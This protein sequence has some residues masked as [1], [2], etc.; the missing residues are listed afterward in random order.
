MLIIEQAKTI[1]KNKALH[2]TAFV[3]AG[4]LVNGLSLF[5]LNIALARSL[6]QE[7]FG[8]FSLSV[9]A[10]SVVA[11][12][13]DFGLNAGLSRFAPY[14][15]ATNQ[16]DKLKQLVKTIWRWRISLTWVLT[17]GGLV[18]AYPIAK[19]VYGQVKLAP[20]LAY[21]TFGVGGV[22]LLGFLAT[23]LQA[24]QKFLYNATVQ[25]FKGLLRLLIA[26]ILIIFGVKSVFA[27]LSVYIFVPWILFIINFK[28]LPNNFRKV[29]I[30]FESKRNLHS[31]LAKFSFWLTIT[32]LVS[33][34]SSRVD[35]IMISH[36]LGLAEVAVFT[37]AWQ[38]LQFF[39]VVTGS[40]SSVLMPRISSLKNKSEI[41][42]FVKR[43]FKWILVGTLGVAV[44]VYPSQYLISL[45]FGNKYDAAMPLY[46]I[47]AYSTLFNI[48]AIPFSLA[49]TIYNKTHISTIFS[50][51]H[52]LI[53]VVGNFIFI[54]LFGIMGAAYTFAVS[55]A[56]LF[57]WNLIL[58]LYLINKKDF[59]IA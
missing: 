44:L 41:I 53:N 6:D 38:L 59:K 2:Q 26:L 24:N 55:S 58:A 7:F 19:Y 30:D 43:A 42:I 23:F 13:S 39:P 40:I 9:V 10:L 48:I 21:A 49:V 36:Y 34:L 54:P 27:Y 51:L 47:L 31:Q 20:Y 14:Y 57:L 25:S 37:V 29:E 12:M 16:T 5:V 4:S 28:I 56:I 3:T 15:L 8:I 32:S 33:I 1:L 50:F 52:L 11:E 17:I 45:F 35:Q 22:I 46:V 18:F